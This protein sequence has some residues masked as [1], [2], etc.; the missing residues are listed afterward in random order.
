MGQNHKF[1]GNSMI[2]ASDLQELYAAAENALNPLQLTK[3]GRYIIIRGTNLEPNSTYTLRFLRRSRKGTKTGRW[4]FVTPEDGYRRLVKE[5][6]GKYTDPPAWLPATFCE[7]EITTDKNGI[8]EYQINTRLLFL[9]FVKPLGDQTYLGDK[10]DDGVEM[11][12]VGLNKKRP[13]RML[14]FTF[15][16]YQNNMLVKSCLNY[17]GINGLQSKREEGFLR[18]VENDKTS[19]AELNGLRVQI[20]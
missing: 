8:F 11:G 20:I 15:G 13:Y 12:L 14:H 7:T 18:V 9:P 16:L 3:R 4:L 17:I 1:S 6:N 10:I 5:G 19:K 2:Y